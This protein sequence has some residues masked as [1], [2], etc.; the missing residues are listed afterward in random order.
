[1]DKKHS[2]PLQTQEKRVSDEKTDREREKGADE[3]RY[4]VSAIDDWVADDITFTDRQSQGTNRSR[5]KDR[6]TTSTESKNRSFPRKGPAMR[7]DRGRNIDLKSS[8][9]RK[10]NVPVESYK[11]TRMN[12]DG[13]RQMTSAMRRANIRDT[14]IGETQQ[15]IGDGCGTAEETVSP[16]SHAI[17]AISP[18]PG[19]KPIT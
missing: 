5:P 18:P 10:Y 14:V 19:F 13:E 2:P 16:K 17:K 15:R 9:S 12:L 8:A 1:M 4:V 6:D 3:R 11:R 7:S